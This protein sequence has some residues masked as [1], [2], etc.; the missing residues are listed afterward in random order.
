MC[1]DVHLILRAGRTEVGQFGNKRVYFLRWLQS[2]NLNA[3]SRFHVSLEVF[4]FKIKGNKVRLQAIDSKTDTSLLRLNGEF[5]FKGGV[6]ES[7][8]PVYNSNL[9]YS[10]ISYTLHIKVQHFLVLWDWR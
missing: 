5:E 4:Y 6:V 3:S 2:S 9:S 8:N 10:R 7:T 1:R